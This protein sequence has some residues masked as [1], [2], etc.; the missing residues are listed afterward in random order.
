VA[1]LE[2]S[3]AAHAGG[4]RDRPVADETRDFLVTSSTPLR[5][6]LRRRALL[7][8]QSPVRIASRSSA[9]RTTAP[10]W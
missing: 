10:T 9:R 4:V 1:K 5:Y 8:A 6:C 3:T 2:F 7:Q